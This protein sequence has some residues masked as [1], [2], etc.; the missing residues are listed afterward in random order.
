M[1]LPAA[2]AQPQLSATPLRMADPVLALPATPRRMVDPILALP[3]MLERDTPPFVPSTCL[4]A[5]GFAH[6]PKLTA[7]PPQVFPPLP[8]PPVPAPRPPSSSS[9]PPPSFS[10]PPM[11]PRPCVAPAAL[12]PQPLPSQTEPRLW[13]R[14]S[15]RVTAAAAAKTSSWPERAHQPQTKGRRFDR[16]PPLSALAMVPPLALARRSHLPGPKTWE[17]CC[18]LKPGRWMPP[19][20]PQ[21]MPPEYAALC[22]RS[23]LCH[24]PPLRPIPSCRVPRQPGQPAPPR[25]PRQLHGVSC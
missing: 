15:V 5:T 9:S 23:P 12:M 19:V 25:L 8:P 17:R 16:L 22:R 10:S 13:P 4:A 2:E 1:Q 3:A 6:L 21:W 24:L 7:P 14:P 20:Y 11:V 18:H